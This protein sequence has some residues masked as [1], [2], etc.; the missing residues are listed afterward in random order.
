[1][2]CA[3][4]PGHD[5]IGLC[6]GCNR[7]LCPDCQAGIEQLLCGSCLIGHNRQVIKHCY[8]RL[9]LAAGCGAAV[10]A[11]LVGSGLDAGAA[12]L[13]AIMATFFPFGWSALSRFFLPSGG[14]FGVA[15]R[16]LSLGMHIAVSAILGFFVGPYQIYRVIREIRKCSAAN[17]AV[18]SGR[19]G[20]TD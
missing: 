16:W 15:A 9:T 11:I 8:S 4:H 10:L 19:S 20:D 5:A 12:T 2:R 17:A 14:Y 18:L 3:Y 6:V 1:M 13:F 7:A